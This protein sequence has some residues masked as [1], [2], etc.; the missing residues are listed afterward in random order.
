MLEEIISCVV[1]LRSTDRFAIAVV[2]CSTDNNITNAGHL[3]REYSR[4]LWYFLT[5]R[6]EME[7]KVTGRGGRSPL[8]QD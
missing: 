2:I 6:G 3:S 4:L 7:C 5:H 1:W 8:I